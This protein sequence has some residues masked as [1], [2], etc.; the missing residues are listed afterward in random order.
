VAFRHPGIR[1][2]ELPGDHCHGHGLHGEDRSVGM[3]Q[4]VETDCRLD[5][6]APAGVAHRA[7]LLG[8]LPGA[9]VLAARKGLLWPIGLPSAK[10]PASTA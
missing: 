1:M 9:A 4:H 7:Q 2:A 5:R 8:A 10:R 6:C 3:P